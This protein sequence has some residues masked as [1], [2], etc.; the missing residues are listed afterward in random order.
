MF[1]LASGILKDWFILLKMLLRDV[2]YMITHPREVGFVA[3]R[4]CHRDGDCDLRPH[5]RLN[6]MD[7]RNIMRPDNPTSIANPM[8]LSSPAYEDYRRETSWND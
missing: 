3:A 8:S 1:E 5:N 6:P 4:D 2:A 7:P